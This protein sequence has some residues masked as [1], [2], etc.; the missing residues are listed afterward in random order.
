MINLTNRPLRAVF[1]SSILVTLAAFCCSG[2]GGGKIS[3]FGNY[4]GFSVEKYDEWQRESKYIAMRDG[5]R[6]AFD[7]VRPVENGLVIEQALPAVWAYYRYHRAREKDGA[8]LS[9]VDRLPPLQT[10][11]THGY[12]IVVVDSRGTGASFGDVRMG[13]YTLQEA[14]YAYEITEW[15]ASQ[16]W[17]DGNVGMFGHSYSG[18][19]Q[20]MAA[21]MMPPHLNAIFPSGAGFDF[22]EVIYPGGVFQESVARAISESLRYWDIEADAVP[23]DGDTS[24]R[25]LK[26]ARLKHSKNI[27]P[28]DFFSALPYRDSRYRDYAFWLEANPMTY[29]PGCN[30]SRI[31]VYHWIGWKDFLRRDEFQWYV[32]LKGPQKLAAGWW[33][34]DIS[35]SYDLLAVEQLRWFD[36]WLKGIKNGIMDESPIHYCCIDDTGATD[37]RGAKAWPLP[38]DQTREFLFVSQQSRSG[39]PVLRGQLIELTAQGDTRQQEI[40]FPGSRELTFITP[41]LDRDLIVIG[42]PVVTLYLSTSAEDVDVHVTLHELDKSQNAHPLSAAVLRASHRVEVEPAFDNMN[43]PYHRHFEDDVVSIPNHKPVGLGFDLLPTANLFNRGNRIRVSISCSNIEY[44]GRLGEQDAPAILLHSGGDL[45]SKISL[46]VL[47]NF[48]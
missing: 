7:I 31:P 48:R 19:T 18:I 41:P 45:I 10:L 1:S 30:Q 22:Y 47:E 5:I 2:S 14:Q 40:L 46:P 16:D 25:L 12:V 28:F 29:L 44:H 39:E 38:A 33:S 26:Q 37:W 11:I 43:L 36:Y 9:L 24:G 6:L 23:V 8:I 15:I 4:K 32:N 35:D 21:A 20:F 13:P 34:H 17:C 3:E 42:H 27:D